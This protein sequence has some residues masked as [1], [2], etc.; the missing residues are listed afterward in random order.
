[1]D[2]WPRP[3]PV[4]LAHAPVEALS[5]W[6]S[7]HAALCGVSRTGLLRHCVPDVPSLSLLNRALTPEQEARLAHLFRLGRPALRRMTHAEL[8]PDVIAHLV[9]HHIDHWCK[10]SHALAEADFGKVVL[11]AWFHTWRITC[12]QCG[13]RVLPLWRAAARLGDKSALPDLFPDLWAKAR[14]SACR[15]RCAPPC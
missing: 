15:C 4:L 7:R 11:R 2:E 12:V 1:M 9:A 6:V 3:F 5:S 14:A 8:D 13:A 10:P